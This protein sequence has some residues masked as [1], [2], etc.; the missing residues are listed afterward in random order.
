MRKLLITMLGLVLLVASAG[1]GSERD[2]GIN[3]D[4]DK[5]RTP[6]SEKAG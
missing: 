3:K 5:P 1:C 6:S 4:R 2:R